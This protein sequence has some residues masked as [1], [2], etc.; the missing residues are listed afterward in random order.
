MA[1]VVTV[2]QVLCRKADL[3]AGITQTE[4]AGIPCLAASR[5]VGSTQPAGSQ[6]LLAAVKAF[7]LAVPGVG[8]VSEQHKPPSNAAGK[9]PTYCSLV[10]AQ[11]FH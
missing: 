8:K 9:S 10:F 4:E 6:Q 7:S 5:Q 3:K 11:A 1:R 2:P